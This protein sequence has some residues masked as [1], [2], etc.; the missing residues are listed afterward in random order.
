MFPSISSVSQHLSECIKFLYES[1]TLSNMYDQ[2]GFP[3]LVAKHYVATA[4]KTN[5]INY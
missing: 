2:N 4:C 5:I 3:F 1:L